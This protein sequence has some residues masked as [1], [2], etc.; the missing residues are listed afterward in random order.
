MGVDL[1]GLSFASTGSGLPG[2]SFSDELRRIL[3]MP[4]RDPLEHA[5]A[6]VQYLTAQLKTPAGTM[7]LRPL[8][9]LGLVEAHDYQGMLGLLPVGEGKTLLSFLLPL[10]LGAA[11]PVLVVPASLEDKTHEEFAELREHWQCAPMEVTSYELI[12]RRP[13]LLDKLAPDLLICDE[14]HG[15]KDPK[16]AAT[17]RV[18]RY[19]RKC[20]TEHR[21]LRFCGLSGTIASRSFR[22]WWHIQQWA[23]PPAVQPL[24]YRYPIMLSW[25]EALDEKL[26]TRRPVGELTRLAPHDPTPAG[27]RAAFGER[28][29]LTPGVISSKGGEVAASIHFTVLQQSIPAIDEAVTTMRKTWATPAEEFTEAVD[30]WRHAREMGNGFYYSQWNQSGFNACLTAVLNQWSAGALTQGSVLERCGLTPS[31]LSA[32]VL[33]TA[34]DTTMVESLGATARG[35]PT[36]SSTDC[37]TGIGLPSNASGSYSTSTTVSAT[38][39][40]ERVARAGSGRVEASTVSALITATKQVASEGC[41]AHL[42]IERLAHWET[43]LKACPELSTILGAAVRAAQPPEEWLEARRAF[44][45][46]VRQVLK[47]SRTYDTMGQVKA[48]FPDAPEVAAWAQLE[49]TF[50]PVTVPVWFTDD[51]VEAAAAWAKATGGLVWVE[52]TAVGERLAER[53]SIPYF[54]EQGRSRIGRSIL[55]HEGAAVVSQKAVSKGFNLQYGWHQNLLLN[56]T[57]AGWRYEQLIGRTHRQGQAHDT[58]Y[59]IVV[60]TVAEQLAGFQQA[61]ADALYE[62]QTTGQRQKLCLADVTNTGALCA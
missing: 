33:Q 29:R 57:P 62:Q 21:R 58:V 53:Y 61:Q 38:S 6:L 22:D 35:T 1:T 56:V 48:A 47:N 16:S 5:D 40:S 42:A 44:N 59:F 28:L 24:P 13:T 25:C 46:Y 41:S 52:H 2:I 60:V 31:T 18:W 34:R 8:Q 19:I 51:V 15:L 50:D 23:L 12:S 27:I 9:A 37:G 49:H 30:M 32:C 3:D 36:R 55:H 7:T 10:V 11:R 17:K 54:G 45:A 14:V 26:D 39:A 20:A 4:L 43:M